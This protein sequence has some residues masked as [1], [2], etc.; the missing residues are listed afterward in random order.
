MEVQRRHLACVPIFDTF[1][2]EYKRLEAWSELVLL[3]GGLLMMVDKGFRYL[4]NKFLVGANEA[5]SLWEVVHTAVRV[6]CARETSSSHI[7]L[8]LCI[9]LSE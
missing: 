2:E 3:T 5:L 1:C 9:V 4:A 8:V 7:Y 6:R